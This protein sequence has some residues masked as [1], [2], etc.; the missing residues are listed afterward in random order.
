MPN[1]ASISPKALAELLEN[2]L[3]NLIDVREPAEY[4]R[5]SIK[6][7][8]NIPLSVIGLDHVTG[9]QAAN[10]KLVLQ[11][12]LGK[13]SMTACQKLIAANYAD[14]IFNLEGGISAWMQAGLPVNSSPARGCITI[15]QGLGVLGVLGLLWISLTYIDL[16]SLL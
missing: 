3:V 7:A 12:Q 6:G 9:E 11:C 15:S 1:I 8:R 14:E 13:R 10:K 4:Q 16:G 5:N 2:N